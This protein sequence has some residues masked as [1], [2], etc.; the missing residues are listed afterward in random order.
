MN[1]TLIDEID[2]LKEGIV[3]TNTIPVPR[4]IVELLQALKKDGYIGEETRAEDFAL[5]FGRPI[6]K[7][8]DAFTKIR[9][10]AASYLL[11]EFVLA[12]TRG[13]QEQPISMLCW[14]L[15]TDKTGNVDSYRGLKFRRRNG[16]EFEAAKA[17][18]Q[19]L[20]EKYCPKW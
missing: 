12:I 19:E 16:I 10:M 18:L 11:Y 5:L 4:E 13:Q 7:K 1:F 3:N 9:W 20:I 8:E 17:L 15:F 2:D 14:L 6:G